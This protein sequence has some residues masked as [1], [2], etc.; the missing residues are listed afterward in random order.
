[1]DRFDYYFLKAFEYC[2]TTDVD[3]TSMVNI[4]AELALTLMK[5]ADKKKDKLR[6]Q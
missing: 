2:W 4:A 5:V 6:S 3:P 1:M